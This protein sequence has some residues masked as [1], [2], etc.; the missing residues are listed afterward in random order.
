MF[1]VIILDQG[2]LLII[3]YCLGFL[4]SFCKYFPIQLIGFCLHKLQDE[5]EI[6]NLCR[7]LCKNRIIFPTIPIT[8]KLH[9]W[10]CIVFWGK[11]NFEVNGLGNW[12]GTIIFKLFIVWFIYPPPIFGWLSPTIADYPGQGSTHFAWFVSQTIFCCSVLSYSRCSPNRS[13]PSFTFGKS[14]SE[15][16]R[17]VVMGSRH[18]SVA[19][20]SKFYTYNWLYY[21][22]HN[23][24][25]LHL[26]SLIPKFYHT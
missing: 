20:Y 19:S 22:S 3:P 13:L 7:D 1:N 23:L 6:D 17:N 16:D 15:S 2:V 18:W 8:L 10:N 9:L 26:V 21:F 12:L 5:E 4:S 25:C 24:P 11:S 14:Y